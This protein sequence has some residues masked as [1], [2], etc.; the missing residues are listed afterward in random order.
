MSSPEEG[1]APPMRERLVQSRLINSPE[2]FSM[3]PKSCEFSTHLQVNLPNSQFAKFNCMMG[4]FANF[5]PILKCG[6]LIRG[7]PECD[8]SILGWG[9]PLAWNGHRTILF[10]NFHRSSRLGDLSAVFRIRENSVPMARACMTIMIYHTCCFVICWCRSGGVISILT[11]R[12]EASPNL[13][14]YPNDTEQALGMILLNCTISDKNSV[15]VMKMWEGSIRRASDIAKVESSGEDPRVNK[16]QQHTRGQKSARQSALQ[17]WISYMVRDTRIF[18]ILWP[19]STQLGLSTLCMWV[20]SRSEYILGLGVDLKFELIKR[21]RHTHISSSL[22]RAHFCWWHGWIFRWLEA[23]FTLLTMI[24]KVQHYKSQWCMLDCFNHNHCHKYVL[25][26][27]FHITDLCV[28]F[29]I[30]IFHWIN[31]NGPELSHDTYFLLC[32]SWIFWWLAKGR[33]TPKNDLD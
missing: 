13:W 28:V 14:Y 15:S 3:W 2:S 32:L 27:I 26:L 6:Q 4:K 23:E 5:A 9:C 10:W 1:V 7:R 16:T 33:G 22:C 20:S 30:N 8:F 12:G 19:F 11:F 18:S 31:S 17:K 25:I 21:K 29:Q 24:E